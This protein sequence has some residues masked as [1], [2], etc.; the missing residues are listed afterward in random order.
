[1]S[2]DQRAYRVQGTRPDGSVYSKDFFRLDKA[3][4]S[5]SRL[6]RERTE[7]RDGKWVTIPAL[8]GVRIVRSAPL[9]WLYP[10]QENE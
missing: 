2:H 1:V 3:E 5:A 10:E 9:R 4:A 8:T 6:I 7:S